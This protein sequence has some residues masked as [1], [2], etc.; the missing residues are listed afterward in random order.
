[1]TVANYVSLFSTFFIDSYSVDTLC[2]LKQ[3]K[4][5][6]YQEKSNFIVKMNI[7]DFR[8]IVVQYDPVDFIFTRLSLL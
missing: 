2:L 4:Q 7:C 3:K 8:L 6:I 1:M 5:A